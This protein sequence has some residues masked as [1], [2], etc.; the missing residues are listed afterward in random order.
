MT[1]F[2]SREILAMESE[3]QETRRRMDE[4]IAGD[5]EYLTL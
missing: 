5:I 1:A 2:A 4:A 3:L